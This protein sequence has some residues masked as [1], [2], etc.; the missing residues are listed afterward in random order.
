M[1]PIERLRIGPKNVSFPDISRTA[2]WQNVF[3][4]ERPFIWYHEK[5][6]GPLNN[7]WKNIKKFKKK[8]KRRSNN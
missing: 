4:I 5:G 8:E 2:C 1:T 6:A 7:G 3:K